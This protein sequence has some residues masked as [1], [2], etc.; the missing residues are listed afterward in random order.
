[1][2]N[3]QKVT[4]NI[5]GMTCTG[6]EYKIETKLKKT[7]GIII[8]RADYVKGTV[9]LTFDRALISLKNIKLILR[10]LDYDVIEDEHKAK[11]EKSYILDKIIDI[12]LI[13][14]S[15]NFIYHFV[16]RVGL[17]E[18]FNQFPKVEANMGYGLLFIV[19]VL[20]SLHCVAMCG[21]I[22]LSASLS[23]DRET[24]KQMDWTVIKP[25]LFYNTGRVV[26]YTVLGGIIGGLGQVVSF[27]GSAKGIV[28]ILAGFFMMIMGINLLNL[29][30]W[31]KAYTPRMPRFVSNFIGQAKHK[32]TGRFYTGLLNGLMPCGPL[33][34][35][36]LYALSTG[37]PI[38]G[39]LSMFFFSLGTVPLMF[40]LGAI[41]A[42]LSRKFT[43]KMLQVSAIMVIILG[44]F[45]FQT[46]LGV[47][48]FALPSFIS[49]SNRATNVATI[50]EGIQLVSSNITA[51]S[52]E[53][54]TV[55][56]GKPV[57]WTIHVDRGELN[58]CNNRIIIPRL[59]LEISLK[60]GD[61]FIEFEP[62]EPGS[63]TF[64]C[65]MGMIRSKIY[66]I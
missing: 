2:E 32:H 11:E 55:E 63:L 28:A 17:L 64:T 51:G 31:L 37:D 6:C 15:L 40:G 16:A 43:E 47:S 7:Q 35:M 25:S 34:A 36:Q 61:N 23:T 38:K 56:A 24:K 33:Q 12:A 54:I 42:F 3:F 29:F 20:T 59:G 41:S 8:V 30:P 13:G 49:G 19:G 18:I 66:I 4:L 44:F 52:Y 60:E 45:M 65:W 9:R 10:K 14:L 5:A 22:N 53:S 21:G 26:S 58:G 46:G 50:D 48:G 62:E 57:Q 39:A 1:M 27:S